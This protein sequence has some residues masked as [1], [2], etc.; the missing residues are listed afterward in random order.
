MSYARV[1]VFESLEERKLLSNAHVTA[2]HAKPA[3]VRL[4]SC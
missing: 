3:V 1:L 2:A 4:R